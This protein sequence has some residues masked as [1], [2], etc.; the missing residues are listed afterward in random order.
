MKLH[1]LHPLSTPTP[2]TQRRKE[3]RKEGRKRKRER[4]TEKE[5]KV[6]LEFMIDEQKYT[7]K[8]KNPQKLFS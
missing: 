4:K 2:F 7:K 6:A 3:G 8:E 5:R 1:I